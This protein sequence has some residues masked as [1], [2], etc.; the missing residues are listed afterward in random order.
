MDVLILRLEAPLMSFG[1]VQVDDRSPTEQFPA[2]SM[3]AGMI[4]NALGYTH[5]NYQ[6]TQRLQERLLDTRTGSKA[7][8][9]A[10]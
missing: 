3:I 10:E 6:K 5:R 7:D 1:G 9:I 4:A 2:Q 8:R